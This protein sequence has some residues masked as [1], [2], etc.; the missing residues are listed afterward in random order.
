MFNQF[1]K[2]LDRLGQLDLSALD[3]SKLTDIA[4]DVPF[5]IGVALTVT[6]LIACLVG[7]RRYPFRFLLAP[8]AVAA[9]FA[10]GP[11]LASLVHLAPKFTSYAAAGLLGLGAVVWPPLVLFAAL[12]LLGG[13]VGAELAGE[14][15]F[16]LGFVPGFVLGGI[17]GLAFARVMAVIVSSAIGGVMFVLGLLTL[18]SFTKAAGL[19]FSAPILA[20]GLA[21]CTAVAGMAFQFKFSPEDDQE[22]RDKRKAEKRRDKEFAADAKARAKRFKQYDK[23]AEAASKRQKASPE[24]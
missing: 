8:F 7:G 14:K 18:L 10:A 12:G 22:A 17:L 4:K 20:A 3:A 9:G 15:D 6:G 2:L 5:P 21:G 23:K 11:K 1:L 24:E 13:S 19:A 16:W